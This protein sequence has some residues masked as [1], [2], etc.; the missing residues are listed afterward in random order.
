MKEKSKLKKYAESMGFVAAAAST[1]Y[2]LSQGLDHWPDAAECLRTIFILKAVTRTRYIRPS[3]RYPEA[4]K[5][6][7]VRVYA[8]TK[9]LHLA[10]DA[11]F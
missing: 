3:A 7:E 9:N 4:S 11:G 5:E 2:L 1:R 8:K 10:K 6:F